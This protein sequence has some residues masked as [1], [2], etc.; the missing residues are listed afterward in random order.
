MTVEV[1]LDG[2]KQQGSEDHADQPVHAS[3]TSSCSTA[4][5]STTGKHTVE[6]RKQG[7]RARSTSTPT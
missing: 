2:K 6:I 7:Q 1:W 4:T 3:T 5:R